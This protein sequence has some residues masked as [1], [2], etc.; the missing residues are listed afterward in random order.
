MHKILEKILGIFIP[1]ETK[2][3]RLLSLEPAISY[4]LL[5]KSNLRQKNA[6]ALFDYQNKLVQLLIKS[7]K[8]KNNPR[9]RKFLAQIISDELL[10]DFAD[11]KLFSGRNPILI[12]IPMSPKEERERGFNPCLELT[13]EIRATS[14]G[15]IEINLDCLRKIR[16]T[17][18]QIKLS[19]S[20]RLQN[21]KNAMQVFDSQNK[22]RDRDIIVLDD[23]YTT[24]STFAEAR[25]ALLAGRARSVTG[26]FLAH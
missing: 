14:R 20:M 9:V 5:P 12:P 2:L 3:D 15:E 25:R 4:N 8:F 22:I 16:E 19:R 13:K 10:P 21:L 11:R 18:R 26:L 17:E 1:E 23:L 24:G 6:T 7:L